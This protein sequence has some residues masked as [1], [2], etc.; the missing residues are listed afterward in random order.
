M[1]FIEKELLEIDFDHIHAKDKTDIIEKTRMNEINK[2]I[3][4]Q[5]RWS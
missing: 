1:T 3:P 4:A 5:K 2:N